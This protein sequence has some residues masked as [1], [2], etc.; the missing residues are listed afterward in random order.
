[1]ARAVLIKNSKSSEQS[2]AVFDFSVDSAI[3]QFY[4]FLELV[5]VV[6]SFRQTPFPCSI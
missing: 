1:L 5:T 2:L 3:L 6:V 4:D